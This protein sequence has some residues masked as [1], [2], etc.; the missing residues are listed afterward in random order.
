M[1]SVCGTS[2]AVT[3]FLLGV[4]AHTPGGRTGSLHLAS[5]LLLTPPRLIRPTSVNWQNR[6]WSGK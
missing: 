6:P 4:F 2:R 1:Q 5:K 3:G